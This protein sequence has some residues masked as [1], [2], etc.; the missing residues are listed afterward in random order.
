MKMHP[1]NQ[2]TQDW[3]AESRHEIQEIQKKTCGWCPISLISLDRVHLHV[4][5]RV[6]FLGYS[7][8][9]SLSHWVTVH[10][11]TEI[12]ETPIG[13]PQPFPG[14]RVISV[15]SFVSW[16]P[17]FLTKTQQGVLKN[18]RKPWRNGWFL[19]GFLHVQDQARG[20]N[21]QMFLEFLDSQAATSWVP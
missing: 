3:P 8:W 4:H 6:F 2:L 18:P 13:N 17:P 16:D 11:L 1:S 7:E 14:G 21:C 19:V 15:I 9:D 10:H 12:T 5:L 20:P